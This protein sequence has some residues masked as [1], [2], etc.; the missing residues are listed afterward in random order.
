MKYFRQ[1][2]LVILLFYHNSI[3]SVKILKTD[4]RTAIANYGS[5]TF[6]FT[7]SKVSEVKAV[8]KKQGEKLSSEGCL[9]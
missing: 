6:P 8:L 2:D 7:E 5:M 1:L 9:F 4:G 3:H